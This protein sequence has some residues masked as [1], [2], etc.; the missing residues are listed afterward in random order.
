M[1]HMLSRDFMMFSSQKN[2]LKTVEKR[3]PN[4]EAEWQ[5]THIWL[6]HRRLSIVDTSER[7]NQPMIYNN[8]VITFKFK[9]NKYT[10]S[11]FTYFM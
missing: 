1:T 9:M 8:F 5:D 4:A 3:G 6:G 7:G 2:A 11:I 10:F